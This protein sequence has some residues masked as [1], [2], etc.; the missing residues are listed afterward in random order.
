MAS[1]MTTTSCPDCGNKVSTKAK[2]CPQCGSP[3]HQPS[4]IAKSSAF[5]LAVGAALFF[6]VFLAFYGAGYGAFLLVIALIPAKIASSKGE[7]FAKWYCYSVLL[8]IVAL[9]H[10]MILGN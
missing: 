6:A 7:D 1:K 3:F 9:I 4:V 10:S 2:A 5:L 8:F